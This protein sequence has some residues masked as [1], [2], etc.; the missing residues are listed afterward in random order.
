VCCDYELAERD[1]FFAVFEFAESESSSCEDDGSEDGPKEE[2]VLLFMFV[3]YF[4]SAFA[5]LLLLLLSP[6]LLVLWIATVLSIALQLCDS[7]MRT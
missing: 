5:A 4:D 2:Y 1:L 6:L 7:L 3:N